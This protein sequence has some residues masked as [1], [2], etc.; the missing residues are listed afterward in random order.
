MNHEFTV[1]TP[2][3]RELSEILTALNQEFILKRGRKLPLELRYPSLFSAENRH[4]LFAGFDKNGT[5]LSFAATETRQL[6]IKSQL[7]QVFLIGSVFTPETMRGQGYCGKV[8]RHI[9]ELFRAQGYAAG[10]LWTGIGRFYE[11][12]GWTGRD[13]SV[14]LIVRDKIPESEANITQITHQN[15]ILLAKSYQGAVSR[16]HDGSEYFKVPSPA[17]TAIR[18]IAMNGNH[19]TG[20]LC[21]G[22]RESTGYVYEVKGKN[23]KTLLALLGQFQQ[24]SGVAEIWINLLPDSLEVKILK[25]SLPQYELKKFNLQMHLI[26]NPTDD[27]QLGDFIFPFLDRI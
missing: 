24:I 23:T 18:L 15:A 19:I 4:N 21:G 14:V 27:D 8:L 20:Y 3:D 7:Y 12:L 17:D 11:H 1:R 6:H 16:S 10:Y 25:Q 22:S 2:D 13:N 26:F 5:L 9:T